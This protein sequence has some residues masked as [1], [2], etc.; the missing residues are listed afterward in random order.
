MNEKDFD[1]FLPATEM[2]RGLIGRR[3]SSVELVTELRSQ[4]ARHNPTLNAIIV[5]RLDEAED[6][7]GAADEKRAAGDLT[8]LLGLPLTIKESIDVAGLPTTGGMPE[9]SERV[10]DRDAPLVRSLK[11]AGAIILGKTNLPYACDDWQANSPVYGRTN[12]P[13]DLDRTPGG[14]TGGGSAALASGMTP[15]E[16]GSDIGG[17]IRF[18]AAFCGVYGHRQSETLVPRSGH[19]PGYSNP[20]PAMVL[21]VMGPLA[22]TPADLELALDIICGP[23]PIED[24]AWDVT[25]P[26]S[27]H[28][29]LDEFRVA[30]FPFLD[31]LPVSQAVSSAQQ[32]VVDALSRRG[33]QVVEDSPE[34]F[35]DLREYHRTYKRLLSSVTSVDLD[36]EA[37]ERLISTARDRGGEF[38]ETVI[39]ALD[40]TP[41]DFLRW[42]QKRETYRQR[43]REFFERYD[44]LLAPITLTPPF[45]HK[46]STQPGLDDYHRTIDIDGVEIDYDLQVVYPALTTLCGQPS[47]AFPAGL[48]ED[49]LPVALQ[50]IGPYLE[51]RTP[52]RFVELLAQEIGGFMPPPGYS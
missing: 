17:S 52:L 41:A 44:I 4:I 50:A 10:P 25:L 29:R 13:W 35:G 33:I 20:N 1:P 14:S 8:P 43:Y 2:L 39:D 3:W 15:L 27:R 24:V 49:G 32:R 48:G 38:D 30:V 51:D 23:E 26:E 46:E 7:A 28:I 18:P 5:D 42:H 45:Q 16:M 34:E 40:G 11:E 12:N 31:W 9:H 19:F 47:T 37:R 36:Q 6:D 21:N 22:R